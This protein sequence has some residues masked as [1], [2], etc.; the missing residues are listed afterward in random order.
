MELEEE[1]LV[2]LHPAGGL[3]ILIGGVRAH[4]LDRRPSR[5]VCPLY[6]PVVVGREHEPAERGGDAPPLGRQSLERPVEDALPEGLPEGVAEGVCAHLGLDEGGGALEVSRVEATRDIGL[7]GW[8]EFSGPAEERPAPQRDGAR[9]E[10]GAEQRDDGA[11]PH[12][13]EDLVQVPGVSGVHPLDDGVTA[14][15]RLPTQLLD[16]HGTHICPHSLN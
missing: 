16:G 4:P 5:L 1:A 14:R 15:V 9:R 13:G 12:P 2:A 7:D 3:D 8:A 6:E 10:S 11:A